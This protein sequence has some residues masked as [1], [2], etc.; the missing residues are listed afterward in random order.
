MSVEQAVVLFLK[1]AINE[2]GIPFEIRRKNSKKCSE[3][4]GFPGMKKLKKY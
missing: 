3:N 2:Q 4:A 1:Q